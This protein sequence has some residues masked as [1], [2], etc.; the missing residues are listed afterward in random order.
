MSVPVSI[1][2]AWREV[3][4][5]FNPQVVAFLKAFTMT[6]AALRAMFTTVTSA[7][8][9]AGGGGSS[10]EVVPAAAV[11]GAATAWVDAH[12]AEVQSWVAVAHVAHAAPSTGPTAGGQCVVVVGSGFGHVEPPSV[13]ATI[14]ST[15]CLTT[16]WINDTAVECLTP[17]GTTYAHRTQLAAPDSEPRPC[18]SLTTV[19]LCRVYPA[20]V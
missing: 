4:L 6:P 15:D 1:Q 14:G 12:A 18:A 9:E 20:Q 19:T 10:A 17:P 7:M 16:R 11:L 5:F 8:E 3:P 2:L 13:V